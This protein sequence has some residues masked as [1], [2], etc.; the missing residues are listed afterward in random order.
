MK[1]KEKDSIHGRVESTE[2]SLYL[3]QA[4]RYMRHQEYSVQRK[5][6]MFL[7]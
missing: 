2:D 7:F 4:E 3:R 5:R 6:M 1:M